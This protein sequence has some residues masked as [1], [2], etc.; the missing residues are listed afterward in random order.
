MTAEETLDVGSDNECFGEFWDHPKEDTCKGCPG[1]QGCFKKFHKET[2][3][4]MQK[5]LGGDA[6]LVQLAKALD[7]S[8]EAVLVAMNKQTPSSV[9][10][11]AS[12][13]V[14][15]PP[16][17]LPSNDPP[18]V[19]PAADDGLEDADDL[20]DEQGASEPE[21][22]EDDP[23]E[24]EDVEPTPGEATM[25]TGKKKKAA[26]KKNAAK[27]TKK[28]APAKK[29]AASNKAPAKKAPEKKAP[30]KKAPPVKTPP[31]V[32]SAS[33]VKDPPRAESAKPA[34]GS[35]KKKIPVKSALRAKASADPSKRGAGRRKKDGRIEDPWGRHTWEKRYLRERKNKLIKQLRPSMRLVREYQGETYKVTVLKK[36]Y[37]YNGQM[38]P[39]LYSI[40][41]EITGTREAPRQLDQKGKRPKGHRQLCNWSAPKFFGL[42]VYL[43]SR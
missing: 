13:P 17:S 39:T 1:Q 2:L 27:K 36:Y 40:V 33:E 29:K 23:I 28:K 43:S 9:V 11:Q 38:Y 14:A 15:V 37:K 21:D 34:T 26:S 16:P 30:A 18:P 19:P 6:T 24:P 31:P 35:A 25:A 41:K 12:P 20:E 8:Q 7:V 3:P 4:A 5:K 22:V 42:R 32:S 10:P